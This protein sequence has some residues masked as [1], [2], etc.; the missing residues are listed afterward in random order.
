MKW[1]YFGTGLAFVGIGITLVLALPPP[2]WPKMPPPLVHIGVIIGAVLTI[3][4]VILAIFGA[5]PMMPNPKI[6]FIGMGFAVVLLVAFAA[7]FWLA[8]GATISITED[9]SSVPL[10]RLIAYA[11][12]ELLVP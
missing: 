7:W 11:R 10:K 8:P 5:W 9:V 2:W 6:P 12:L 4:G 1:E 3:V